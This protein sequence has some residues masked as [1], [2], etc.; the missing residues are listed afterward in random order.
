MV[1]FSENTGQEGFRLLRSFA[2][3][4]LS[5]QAPLIH[6]E[7]RTESRFSPLYSLLLSF[8]GNTGRSFA[9]NPEPPAPPTISYSL[10]INIQGRRDLCPIEP[11]TYGFGVRRSTVRATALV[12]SKP[13]IRSEN[14]RFSALS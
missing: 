7:N 8:A 4:S 6:S 13:L 2:S 12:H 5:A 9:S 14:L 1:L 11:P 3:S 10:S